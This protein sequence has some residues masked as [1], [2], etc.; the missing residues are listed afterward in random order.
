MWREMKPESV[1]DE[2]GERVARVP[3]AVPA[4]LISCG[5]LFLMGNLNLLPVGAWELVIRLWPIALVIIGVEVIVRH[6]P[7][8][9]N[10]ASVLLVI[11]AI[12]LIVGAALN[13]P[14]MYGYSYGGYS[15]GAQG[16]RVGDAG[17]DRT[18]VV[19][20]LDEPIGRA[21][22][23]EIDLSIRVGDLRVGALDPG[24]GSL[25]RGSVGYSSNQPAPRKEVATG[26][27]HGVF[28]MSSRGSTG[29]VLFPLVSSSG[30]ESWDLK[31]NRD[32][33][34]TMLVKLDAA[35]ARLDLSA[36]RVTDLDA[37]VDAGSLE[38]TLPA[39]GKSRVHVKSDAAAVTLL[40]P[41][42]AAARI[43]VISDV[44]GVSVDEKRFPRRGD[45]YESG[46]YAGAIGQIEIEI[47]ADVSGITVR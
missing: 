2:C 46:D 3:I 47:D 9:P 36:L 44:S 32:M 25:V 14:S 27:E 5:L 34:M 18:A 23:A 12:G 40:V 43:H 24:S 15:F 29:V 6:L 21:K 41:D 30:G 42:G 28:R 16:P 4:I 1:G 31:L 8:W 19:E 37:D 35:R 22:E 11:A 13:W 33:P 45:Y 20:D 7:F 39:V 17:S 38:V 26:D 10:W